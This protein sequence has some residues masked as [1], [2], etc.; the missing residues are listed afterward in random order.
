MERQSVTTLYVLPKKDISLDILI[1]MANYVYYNP[2]IL[3]YKNF[4]PRVKRTILERDDYHCQVCQSFTCE[5]SLAPHHIDYNK[6]DSH[7]MNLITLCSS[8]H[9]RTLEHKH[10]WLRLFTEKMENRFGEE[11]KSYI[12]NRRNRNR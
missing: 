6:E 8:C 1:I 12:K 11:Y 2:G 3:T 10:D 7:P 5:G 9:R 4:T